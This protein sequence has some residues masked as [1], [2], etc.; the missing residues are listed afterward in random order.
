MSIYIY[1]SLSRKKEEFKPIRQNTVKMYVCGPTVYDEPHIGHARGAFVFDVIRNYFKYKKYNVKYVR[2]I[3]DVDDKIIDRARKIVSPGKDLKTAVK[4]VAEKYLDK[5]NEDMS[6]LGIARPDVEPKATEHIGDMLNLIR[7]LKEKGY[8]YEAGGD[9]YFRVRSFSHYGKLS[10]QGLDLME[11]GARVSPGENKEDPLDFA[12]WKKSKEGEPCWKGG[13]ESGRPGWHIECSAMSMRHLGDNFDIHGGGLDL[14]FPHHENEIAQSES[15]S[16]K[17]FANYW[18]HN[19]LLTINGQKMAKSLGNFLTISDFLN[20]YKDPNVLKIFFLSSHY[21]TPVDF[22][23]EAIGAAKSAV[24]RFNIFFDASEDF[25]S[26][27]KGASLA[28][29]DKE[30]LTHSTSLRVNPEQAKRVEGLKTVRA[31]FEKAMDDDFNTARALAVLFDAVSAGNSM[32]NS[33]KFSPA[34]K[35]AFLK[36]L[37]SEIREMAKVL[38]LNFARNFSASVEMTLIPADQKKRINQ[39]VKAREEAR[40]KKNYKLADEIR[41]DLENKGVVLEDTKQGPKWRVK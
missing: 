24:E 4:E 1:N 2:N 6:A 32:I 13:T 39:K 40:R 14:I 23:D 17:Q 34:K 41:K 20:K 11:A 22:T 5:Y 9:I 25:I 12:L 37:D 8:A 19:G 29:A 31:E 30:S 15:Y 27:N 38:G 21:R 7:G 26:K 28:G 16:G 35:S 33:D 10:H 18:I 36:E 3:T